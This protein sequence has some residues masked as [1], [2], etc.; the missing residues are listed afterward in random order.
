MGKLLKRSLLLRVVATP[1]PQGP[2]V[3]TLAAAAG[4]GHNPPDYTG[5]HVLLHETFQKGVT[6]LRPHS[7]CTAHVG[8]PTSRPSYVRAYT[9]NRVSTSRPAQAA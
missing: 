4:R 5:L 6:S 2:R 3:T 7:A 8:V 1:S 9:G